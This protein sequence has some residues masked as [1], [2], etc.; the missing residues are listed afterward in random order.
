MH[1]HSF[2]AENTIGIPTP[3]NSVYVLDNDLRPVPRG[4]IGVMWAGGAGVSLG[5][6]N[7][8]ELTRERFRPDVV[9]KVGYVC[10]ARFLW[11]K[12]FLRQR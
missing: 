3:N 2:G 10:I 9:R 12:D 4:Q 11:N 8:P 6:L 1:R 5:Y 7:R